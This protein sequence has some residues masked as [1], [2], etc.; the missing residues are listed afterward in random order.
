MQSPLPPLA[1]VLVLLENA[2]DV[3]YMPTKNNHT[4]VR[5]WSIELIAAFGGAIAVRREAFAGAITASSKT[6]AAAIMACSTA[7]VGA[8]AACSEAL[9]NAITM[10]DEEAAEQA[11]RN[12]HSPP[13]SGVH[14][15]V[16]ATPID[17]GG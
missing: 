10:L 15:S 13:Y 1:P 8:I 3:L 16:L 2:R 12:Y 5:D 9:C 6:F 7:F 14:D 11:R 4:S 17:H